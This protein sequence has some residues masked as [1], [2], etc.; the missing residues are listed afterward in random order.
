MT[1]VQLKFLKHV[2]ILSATFQL[3]WDKTSD[4]GSF[5]WQAAKIIVGVKSYKIDPLYTIQVLSHE[6][7][8]V[9]LVGMGARFESNRTGENFL[10]NFDHQTFENAIQIH[11]QA[12]TKFIK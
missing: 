2:E 10:F 9:I 6:I 12:L 8:E 3:E 7:M 11:T 1:S 4:G 5:S